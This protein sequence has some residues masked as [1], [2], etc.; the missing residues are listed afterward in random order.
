MSANAE[1]LL[2]VVDTKNPDSIF[3]VGVVAVRDGMAAEALPLAEGGVED[4]PNDARMW[5]LLGLAYRALDRMGAASQAFEKAARLNPS[6]VLIALSHARSAFEAGLPAVDLYKQALAMAPQDDA[7]LTGLCSALY[8]DKRVDDIVAL[9]ER[10]LAARPSW[11]AG[12]HLYSRFRWLKGERSDFSSSFNAAA[13]VNPADILPWR[14]WIDTLVIADQYSSA[15]EVVERSRAALG[16]HPVT[17]AYEAIIAAEMGQTEQAEA[18]FAALGGIEHVTMAVRY[19]RHLLRSGRPR[20]AIAAMQPWLGPE[21]REMMW[22]YLMTAYRLTSDPRWEGAEGDER[23]VGV[24]D[25]GDQIP[26]L[27]ALAECLRGIHVAVGQPLDQSVRGGTQTD[28][29]LFSRIEPEIQ[30]LRAAIVATV[31]RHVDQLP[32][33]QASHPTLIGKR[34]PISFAGSWSVRL[35]DAGFHSNH[36]HPFGW[37]SSAFYVALPE[38]MGAGGGNGDQGWLALG[39]PQAELGIDLPAFR[40]IEPKPGRLVLFPSTMWHGTRPFDK[41]ERLTVAFDVARPSQ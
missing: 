4:Y 8:A 38:T 36:I 9:L 25:I 17:D 39:E 31:E 7:L 29:P 37:I 32:P 34:R 26:S 16:R 41:G 2:K 6:D 13:Q 15:L 28:G 33:E 40:T 11:L 18:L 24:Y 21:H 20:E 12:H 5:Q 23:L 19:V 27:P 35:A 30:A 22:P 1:W 10:E 14:Q 3:H